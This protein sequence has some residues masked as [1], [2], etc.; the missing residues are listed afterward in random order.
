MDQLEKIILRGDLFACYQQIE[1][2]IT[3]GVISGDSK[4]KYWSGFQVT[5]TE[6]INELERMDGELTALRNHLASERLVNLKLHQQIQEH[7]RLQ[8]ELRE[9]NSNFREGFS[10]GILSEGVGMAGR[11]GDGDDETPF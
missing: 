9:E 8:A 2:G 4:V 11:L 6:A 10:S 5:L 1:N 7:E 3:S